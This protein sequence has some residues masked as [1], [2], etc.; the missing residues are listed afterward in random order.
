MEDLGSR[1]MDGVLAT[2]RRMTRMI[3]VEGTDKPI[4]ATHE[5]WFS[6]DLRIELSRSDV[7][8]FRGTHTTVATNLTKAAPDPAL[9]QVPQGYTVEQAPQHAGRRGPD[10]APQVPTPPPGV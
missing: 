6:P 4:V 1:T 7:D 2:G 9:F 5:V 10:A 8:P 3:P